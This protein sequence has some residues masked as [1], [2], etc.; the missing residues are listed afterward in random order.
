MG[1]AAL[2]G[3]FVPAV[4]SLVLIAVI[5]TSTGDETFES[6]LITTSL[7]VLPIV[8]LVVLVLA[9]AALIANNWVGRMLAAIGLVIL[10]G[11]GVFL[12]QALASGVA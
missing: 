7:I 8:S 6:G 3:A 11:Q 12:V 2:I 4:W 10:I 9:I 5:G 1:A